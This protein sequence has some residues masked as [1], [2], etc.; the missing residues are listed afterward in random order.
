MLSDKVHDTNDKTT[1]RSEPSMLLSKQKN[2]SLNSTSCQMLFYTCGERS[3]EIV[4]SGGNMLSAQR[5]VEVNCFL[6]SKQVLTHKD[7]RL[8]DYNSAQLFILPPE[9]QIMLTL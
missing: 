3:R 7:D 5:K 6:R 2:L 8:S 1:V 4:I 9:A